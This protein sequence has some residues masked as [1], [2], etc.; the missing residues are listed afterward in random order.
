M[1]YAIE[2]M[3]TKYQAFYEFKEFLVGVI[4]DFKNQFLISEDIEELVVKKTI[5]LTKKYEL[6][7]MR[8]ILTLT[9]PLLE[10]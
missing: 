6:S 9:Y 3:V 10:D 7:S 5:D 1:K 4:K 8:D 2:E